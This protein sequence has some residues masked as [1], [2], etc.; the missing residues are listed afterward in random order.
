MTRFAVA[1]GLLAVAVAAFVPGP[2]RSAAQVAAVL[3]GGILGA[4]LWRS[5]RE[6]RRRRTLAGLRALTPGDFEAEVARWLRRDGWSVEPR[7][8]TGDGG[9][10]LLAR[11]REVTLAVQCK[12]YAEATAVTSAQIRDLYGAALAVEA[13]AAALVTTGRVSAPAL[14]W[15]EALPAGMPLAFHDF[16]C[17]ARLAEGSARI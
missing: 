10:D 5:I 12:R 8:G 4:R 15:A 17:L 2:P 7:G 9:I 1:L 11:H 14:A 16:R 13:T 6:R 3:A